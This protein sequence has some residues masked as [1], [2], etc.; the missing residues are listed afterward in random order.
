MKT[1]H[2]LL[3][4]ALATVGGFLLGG[5]GGVASTASTDPWRNT[6]TTAARSSLSSVAEVDAKK[7]ALRI[8][9]GRQVTADKAKLLDSK[10]RIA[11]LKKAAFLSDPT[12]QEDVLCGLVSVMNRK[13]LEETVETLRRAK[14]RGNRWSQEVWDTIWIQWGKQDPEACLAL[15]KKGGALFTPEDCRVFMSG[16]METDPEAALRW[17]NEPGKSRQE[18]ITAAYAITSSAKGDL[19]KMEAAIAGVSGNPAVISSGLHEYFDLAIST[20]PSK[21][22]SVIYDGMTPALKQAAWSTVMARLSYTDPQQ[23]AAW[24]EKHAGDPGGGYQQTQR[25]VQGMSRKDPAKAM[26]WASR[27]PVSSSTGNP[28]SGVHPAEIVMS[29]W[30]DSEPGDAQAWIDSRPAG[31]PFAKRYRPPPAR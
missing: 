6:R 27:L 30:L 22:P 20:D 16:W 31:H 7:A 18:A 13:E 21:T 2:S 29:Q 26:E 24:L 12:K 11:L 5:R 14:G 23:A 1:P 15:A 25:L 28:I 9:P 19:V 10:E 8:R 3:L 4:I 17:A